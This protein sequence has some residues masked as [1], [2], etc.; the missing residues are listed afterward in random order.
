MWLY[1]P[2]NGLYGQVIAQLVFMAALMIGISSCS[3][4]KYVPT[5]TK[6]ETITNY[7]DS[8]RVEVRDSVVIIPRE[9]YHTYG[10]LLDTLKMETKYAKAIAYVDSTHHILN[11]HMESKADVEIRTRTE[12]KD[13]IV[14]KTDTLRVYEE[15]P[16]EVTK[17]VEVVPKWAWWLLAWNIIAIF[18]IMLRIYLKRRI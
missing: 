4:I 13:R 7:V 14:E 17:E 12:Y 15:I 18:V 8:V 5:Q 6:V 10:E 1:E 2:K 9:V 16:V 3:T 11:G